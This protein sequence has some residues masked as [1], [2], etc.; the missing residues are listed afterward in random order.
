[1]GRRESK[2]I[3]KEITKR[4]GGAEREK[5]R[6]RE[7]LCSSEVY[8]YDSVRREGEGGKERRRGRGRKGEGREI[9]E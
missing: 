9:R 7:E 2:R 6:E 1:M 8:D 3:N 5:G 4:R